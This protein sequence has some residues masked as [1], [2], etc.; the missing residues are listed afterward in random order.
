[1]NIQY[2][3]TIKSLEADL[4]GL[5]PYTRDEFRG[6]VGGYG[7]ALDGSVYKRFVFDFERSPFI[8]RRGLDDARRIVCSVSPEAYPEKDLFLL[9]CLLRVEAFLYEQL[10]S[11]RDNA[12]KDENVSL[13]YR[14]GVRKVQR[15]LSGF[16][17][18]A[19][20]DLWRFRRGLL[21]VI[22]EELLQRL[23]WLNTG[24]SAEGIDV[25]DLI[26]LADTLHSLSPQEMLDFGS[27]AAFAVWFIERTGEPGRR[28]AGRVAAPG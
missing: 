11:H 9:V 10:R 2:R 27:P 5:R 6:L 12:G 3:E 24:S 15:V 28:I 18:P 25:G 23:L 14:S 21:D 1:M 19:A 17:G 26:G 13:M 7:S 20:C 4:S 22:E 16:L 8:E